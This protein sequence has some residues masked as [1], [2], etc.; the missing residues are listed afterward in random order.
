MNILAKKKKERETQ[1]V[2]Q[3]CVHT[4]AT[5]NGVKFNLLLLSRA[6]AREGDVENSANTV[7]LFKSEAT[8]PGS[9]RIFF[10]S[11][12]L[13]ISPPISLYSSRINPDKI[14]GAFNSKKKK[15]TIL[16]KGPS[17]E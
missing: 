9:R 14:P 3:Q 15:D 2:N 13:F 6:R 16:S 7:I 12:S 5:G 4:V 8:V 1:K 10:L 11:P 17:R